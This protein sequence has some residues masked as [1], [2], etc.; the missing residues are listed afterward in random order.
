MSDLSKITLPNGDTYDLK[1]A[2]ARAMTGFFVGTCATA[3]GTKDKVV[4][5]TD[6]TGF[7]LTAGV[8]VA[9]KFTYTNTYANSTSNPITLN[10]NSTGAK[11]IWYGATHSGAGNTGATVR[12]YGNANRYIYYMYDGTYWVWLNH[13][14]DDDT[15]NTIPYCIT[16]AGTAAKSVSCAYY[17][18]L[19]NSY[20]PVVIQNTNTAASAL[21][22]NINA[23]GA[24]PIYIN[25]T[26]SS[27][28]NHTLPRG[29]YIVY[30]DGT[31]YYFRTDGKLNSDLVGI[32]CPERISLQGD[33]TTYRDSE[34]FIQDI[35]DNAK[36]SDS[37]VSVFKVNQSGTD[38]LA[39]VQYASATYGTVITVK[40]G[41]VNIWAL[42]NG[43]W[44]HYD[45]SISS[46]I[47]DSSSLPTSSAV[48]TYVDTSANGLKEYVD[49]A[50]SKTTGNTT[51]GTSSN[52]AKDIILKEINAIA[53][54]DNGHYTNTA[55]WSNH[56]NGYM[57]V[58]DKTD[59]MTA[60]RYSGTLYDY[61][62]G[63][64]L[65]TYNGSTL[66]VSSAIA[67]S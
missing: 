54:A 58:I 13:D 27:S 42:S 22:L 14:V 53:S 2:T 48:K 45:Y 3:G 24:K 56:S 9:V 8:V 35:F 34:D 7:S 50:V 23:Q 60:K 61:S 16:A 41:V 36:Q 38:Y 46:S 44:T 43:T 19:T 28:S 32:Y 26:A 59:Y 64:Y 17:T 18:L 33:S 30:Y 55:S 65:F 10:V 15:N 1:D 40:Y 6:A 12:I 49:A 67:M 29:T 31:N 47:A 63:A 37:E 4:T 25:G 39:I 52:T 20:I 62:T 21:T 51:S 11:N 66:K 57:V 5:L